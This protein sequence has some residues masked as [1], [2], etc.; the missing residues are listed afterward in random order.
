MVEMRVVYLTVLSVSGVLSTVGPI[1]N[2]L[3]NLEDIQYDQFTGGSQL[4]KVQK[5]VDT[6][7][8]QQEELHKNIIPHN[9]VIPNKDKPIDKQGHKGSNTI[10]FI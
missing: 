3:W 7:G 10:Y 4:D 6:V 2:T 5:H 9:L 1:M 8:P